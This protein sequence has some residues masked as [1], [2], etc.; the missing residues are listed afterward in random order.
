MTTVRVER[1][2][3]ATQA[4]VWT[5]IAE[6]DAIAVEAPNLSR[7]VTEDEGEGVYRRCW[8][9]ND[10]G[11]DE[12]CVA[13]EASE[14]CTLEVDVETGESPMHRL[15]SGMAGWFGAEARPEEATIWVEFDLAP[16][17][18]PVGGLLGVLARPMVRR[19]A[20]RMLDTWAA[21]IEAEAP[22]EATDGGSRKEEP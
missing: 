16:R 7:A 13:W 9:P 18:G 1:P 4:E 15:L 6:P 3:D 19:G 21:A 11:W 8:D 12:T 5:A 2:V 22:A 17:F 20:G 10:R 14:R